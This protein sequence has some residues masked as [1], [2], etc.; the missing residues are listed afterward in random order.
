MKV[1]IKQFTEAWFLQL[2]HDLKEKLNHHHE[3]AKQFLWQTMKF[4]NLAA[5]AK[6]NENIS[7]DYL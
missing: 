1:A 5:M 6:E 4:W 7:S 3:T 2:K